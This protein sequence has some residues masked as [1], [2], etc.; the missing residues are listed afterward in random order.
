MRA[1]R[2]AADHL[3][4]TGGRD[5]K[6]QTRRQ[7]KFWHNFVASLWGRRLGVLTLGRDPPT[8]RQKRKLRQSS[9]RRNLG[10][11]R[12]LRRWS[13]QSDPDQRDRPTKNHKN[14]Y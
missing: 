6:Q 9:F 12:I 4:G 1:T 10:I 14:R 8:K 2:S 3:A 7:Q 11:I 13:S 5:A